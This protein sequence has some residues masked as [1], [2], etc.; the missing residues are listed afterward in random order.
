M[1]IIIM[2]MVTTKTTET[3]KVT[4]T[5]KETAIIHTA[6]N[7]TITLFVLL[8]TLERKHAVYL[9]ALK[10]RLFAN[11]QEVVAADNGDIIEMLSGS[12]KAVG[13]NSVYT[14]DE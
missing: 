13:Q 14:D 8:A 12:I 3:I 11:F 4:V 6:N 5:I 10:L 1:E 9:K 2:A 7:D